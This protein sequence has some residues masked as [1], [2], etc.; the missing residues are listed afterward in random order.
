VYKRQVWR[1]ITKGRVGL[2]LSYSTGYVGEDAVR[3]LMADFEDVQKQLAGD[4][5]VANIGGKDKVYEEKVVGDLHD[6]QIRADAFEWLRARLDT[7]VNVLR[8][9]IRAIVMDL[10]G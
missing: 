4:A 6:S 10:K 3:T 7:W 9:R 8:P 5:Q 2:T 1:D